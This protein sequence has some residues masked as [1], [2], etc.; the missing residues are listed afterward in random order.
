MSEWS[1]EGVVRLTQGA[2]HQGRSAATDER[3]NELPMG[4]GKVASIDSNLK[5]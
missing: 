4:W 1:E 5:K 2:Q 3:T